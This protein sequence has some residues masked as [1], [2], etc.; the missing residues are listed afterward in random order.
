MADG[1]IS[2]ELNLHAYKDFQSMM[3]IKYIQNMELLVNT[4]VMLYVLMLLKQL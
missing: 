4:L 2:Q 3:V 1:D